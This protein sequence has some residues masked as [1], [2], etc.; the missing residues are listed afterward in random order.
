MMVSASLAVGEKMIGVCP[1]GFRG[2]KGF[3]RRIVYGILMDHD[4]P[5]SI[6]KS[7]APFGQFFGF[8]L[9]MGLH[10]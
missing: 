6:N 7:G 5:K 3:Q 9:M 2:S 4:E 10:W 8:A 1:A